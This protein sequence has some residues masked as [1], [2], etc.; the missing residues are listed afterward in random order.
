MVEQEILCHDRDKR[1]PIGTGIA[2]TVKLAFY[3]KCFGLAHTNHVVLDGI[4]SP[5]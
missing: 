5:F 2:G 1:L 4:K 3:N